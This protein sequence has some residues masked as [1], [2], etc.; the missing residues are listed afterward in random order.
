VRRIGIASLIWVVVATACSSDAGDASTT[1][2]TTTAPPTSAASP[3]TTALAADDFETAVAVV[4]QFYGAGDLWSTQVRSGAVIRYQGQ[5]FDILTSLPEENV[6]DWDGDGARTYADALAR[7]VVSRR[8]FQTVLDVQCEPVGPIVL[9]TVGQT[10]LLYRRA[11][12]EGPAFQ[13]TFLVQDGLIVELTLPAVQA[14]LEADAAD[15]AW[16]AHLGAFEQWVNETYP[17]DYASLFTGPCCPSGL[18][19]TPDTVDLLESRLAEW[20][21]S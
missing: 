2:A 12:V 9:C 19:F 8:V 17:D 10:D 7:I 4:A 13:Q 21:G 14:G 1:T 16:A 5:T 6:E 18:N 3:S 11:G 15:E 20:A